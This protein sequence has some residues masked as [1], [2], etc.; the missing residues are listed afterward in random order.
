MKSIVRALPE[1]ADREEK[2]FAIH[3]LL[4]H[5]CEPVVDLSVKEISH[6]RK[7]VY[8]VSD[9]G[10]DNY[11]GAFH[12]FTN[13]IPDDRDSSKPKISPLP[14]V[15]RVYELKPI[16][17]TRLP[18]GG[19]LAQRELSIKPFKGRPAPLLPLRFLG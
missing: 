17:S 7:I 11:H 6:F 18:N 12:A 13:L 1:T 9:L 8:R 4:R 19:F 5:G 3:Q 16:R 10:I 15:L 14:S 2:L